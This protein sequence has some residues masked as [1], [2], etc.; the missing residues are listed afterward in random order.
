MTII[1]HNFDIFSK[2]YILT[3]L[4]YIFHILEIKI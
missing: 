3:F 4:L 1:V 2:L